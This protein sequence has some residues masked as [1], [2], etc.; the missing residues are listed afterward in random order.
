V[1]QRS[2]EEMVVGVR[3]RLLDSIRQ[4]MRADVA[5]GIYLSGGIDSSV[6]AGMAHHLQTEAGGG[7]GLGSQGTAT[8]AMTCFSVGFDMADGGDVGRDESAAA[9][10]TAA[11]L[12][13]QHH[14]LRVGEAELADNLEQAVYHVEHHNQNLNFV[15]KFLLSRMVHAH[16]YRVVLTGEGADEQFAGYPM[17]RPDA[18]RG[19]AE[20]DANSVIAADGAMARL[21]H[22]RGSTAG[23]QI[24][25]TVDRELRAI[26]TVRALSAYQLA[27][28]CWHPCLP[29]PHPFETLAAGLSPPAKWNMQHKWH[30]L[31]SA[32]YAWTKTH[33]ANSILSCLGDRTE[34]AHS[35]EARTPFLDHH[36]TSY[37]NGLPP[38]VKLRHEPSTGTWTEKWI[39]REAARPFVLPELYARQKHAYT[40]P[41]LYR[42]N[43]PLH[44]LYC[45]LFTQAS[46]VRLGFL[47][48]KVVNQLPH[49]AFVQQ[50]PRAMRSLNLCCQWII[51][52]TKFD[53]PPACC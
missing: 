32:L 50:D 11:W 33:L 26:G 19:Q 15:G 9:A 31:H 5:V 42:V 34:M 28:E 39:L 12:G 16:G 41:M 29:K 2:E 37:V 45:R 43:G 52:S 17:F 8:A 38:A 7:A 35:L 4:R 48:W 3:T 44:R 21:L 36:L 53:M 49:Q 51:L 40:A 27:P 6:V 13:V 23:H 20:V 47:D 25:P 14:V 10:R 22:Q 18:V 46:V 24:P 1:E 30:P